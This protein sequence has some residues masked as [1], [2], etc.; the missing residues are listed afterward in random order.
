VREPGVI[1]LC[2]GKEVMME[3]VE[4]L[5]AAQLEVEYWRSSVLIL[6]LTLRSQVGE[7][8]WNGRATKLCTQLDSREIGATP[9]ASLRIVC[10]Q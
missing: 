2:E 6:S 4:K 7:R 1:E 10:F 8:D 9:A 3:R 5:G